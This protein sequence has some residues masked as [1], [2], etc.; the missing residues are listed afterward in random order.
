[1]VN[2]EF[3]LAFIG[4]AS[5]VA[6]LLYWYHRCACE[7]REEFGSWVAERVCDKIEWYFSR[8]RFYDKDSQDKLDNITIKLKELADRFNCGAQDKNGGRE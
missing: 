2:L 3:V 4:A 8:G 7:A 6:A 5:I 1:M